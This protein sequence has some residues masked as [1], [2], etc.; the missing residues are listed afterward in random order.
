[1]SSAKASS[2]ISKFFL[3]LAIMSF[4]VIGNAQV[5]NANV[6]NSDGSRDLYTCG[7][8]I[9]CGSIH[10]PSAYEFAFSKASSKNGAKWCDKWAG[11]NS[12]SAKH[13][14]K[15]GV[16]GNNARTN[17]KACQDSGWSPKESR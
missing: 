6:Q 3:A 9:G 17:I 11:P 16:R 12:W 2:M 1:M 10:D 4:P 15:E 14:D 13:A 7:T 8:A 5:A